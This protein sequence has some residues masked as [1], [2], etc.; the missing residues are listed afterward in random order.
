MEYKFNPY[1]VLR[2]SG[3]STLIVKASHNVHYVNPLVKMKKKKKIETQY[4]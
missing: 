3:I 2:V 1:V 4:Q